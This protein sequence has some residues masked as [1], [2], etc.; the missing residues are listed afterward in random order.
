MTRHRPRI[1]II[2][3]TL[4][5]IGAASLGTV[6]TA[7]PDTAGAMTAQLSG[8][9]EVPA[10]DT[11]AR[12]VAIFR[13]TAEDE[14]SYRLIAANIE[15]VTMAHIH[16]ASADGAVVAWLYPDAPPPQLI[17]GR[18]SGVLATGTIT[19]A[20]LVGPLVGMSLDAL[21]NAIKAGDAYVNVHTTA[22]PGGEIRG[23]IA[24][25]P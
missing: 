17:E 8:A 16:L 9:E 15:D 14:L 5:L 25:R 12:G 20:D 21:L 18:F 24:F 7:Q 19:G 11:G 13:V 3:A 10:V 1:A 4:S 23:T 2:A 22:N 6:A